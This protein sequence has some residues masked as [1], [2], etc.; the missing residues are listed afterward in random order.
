M[1]KAGLTVD[2]PNRIG[3]NLICWNPTRQQGDYACGYVT[4]EMPCIL[5]T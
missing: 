1:S 3:E 5:P 2:L 4:A